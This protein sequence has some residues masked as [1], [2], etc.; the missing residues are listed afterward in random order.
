MNIP[1]VNLSAQHAPIKSELLAAVENVLDHGQ[2]ILGQEV[3]QFERRFADLCGTS[4]AVGVNSGTDALILALK[5]LGV[6]SGDEVITVSN[7]FVASTG[8]ITLVGASPVF[9]DVREDYNMDPELIG[10]AI[11]ERTKAI[12]LVHLTGRSADMDPILAI[13]REH[14]L[15]VIEDAAQAVGSEYKEKRVGSF[16]DIGCFSLH[17]LKTLN[18]CGDGGVITTND[19][20]LYEELQILRNLGLKERDDCV[21]WGLN[22][23]LDTLQAAILLVKLGYLNEWTDKRRANARFY[24]SLLEELPQVQCPVD[25]P[26]EHAVYH[27]F[28]VQADDR[29]GLREYLS[30][31][32]IGTAIHYPIPI[33]LH[34]AA[35]NLGYGVGSFP[36][37][38]RQAGKILSLPI[39]PELLADQI[40]YVVTS[41]NNYYKRAA[42]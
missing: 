1:F 16:G 7:S 41:L 2:F 31:N 10:Q 25:Q 32:G 30:N 11:T 6:G 29:D 42:R 4:Y 15:Y 28:V 19:A 35:A 3:E 21:V 36:I 22:S 39:Y 5:A 33:H 9:I 8:C 13:A 34:K 37:T 27:T 20:F 14:G 26:Y 12:L 40:E 23:R 24:Q 17:P 38:E 18:A